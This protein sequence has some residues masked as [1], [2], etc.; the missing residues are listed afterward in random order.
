MKQDLNQAFK[1]I[2]EIEP[3]PKLEGLILSK[4]EALKEKRAKK[5]LMLSYFSLAT[6]FGAF[7]LAVVS[8]G[9][10]FVKAEFWDLLKLSITDTGVVFGNW[11]Y[12][13]YSLLETFPVVSLAVILIPILA[14]LFSFSA[15]FKSI[16]R[17]HFN[18]I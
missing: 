5:K 1:N 18:Y 11:S 4:I 13:A 15:Y 6:S 2:K 8:Y 12:F 14:L 16:H 17:S 10:A 3:S 7:V 9:N